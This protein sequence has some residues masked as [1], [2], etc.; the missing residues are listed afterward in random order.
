MNHENKITSIMLRIEFKAN[1][2]IGYV[3][4]DTDMIMLSNTARLRAQID[5]T[6]S[7]FLDKNSPLRV[8][9]T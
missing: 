2:R 8:S 6:I 4:V 1:G 3:E 7:R 5:D 9:Q